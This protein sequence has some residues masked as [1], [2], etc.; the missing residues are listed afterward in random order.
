MIEFFEQLQERHSRLF[1][2][3]RTEE[4]L[5]LLEGE[6]R[7]VKQPD[8][9]AILYWMRLVHHG[10][11]MLADPP[12]PNSNDY[13]QLAEYVSCALKAYDTGSA[14]TQLVLGEIYLKELSLTKLREVSDSLA[15]GREFSSPLEP[16]QQHIRR[17]A[18]LSDEGKFREGIDVM[19]SALPHCRNAFDRMR[20]GTL[21]V[22]TY[23]HKVFHGPPPHG[24]LDY[25]HVR[26]ALRLALDNYDQASPEDRSWFEEGGNDP[27]ALRKILARMDRDEPL[28][29]EDEPATAPASK[30]ERN[31]MADEANLK[32]AASLLDDIEKEA[33][34]IPYVALSFKM[35]MGQEPSVSK[36]E[37]EAI[38]GVVERLLKK[39]ETVESKCGDE[40]GLQ[41]L[42]NYWRG[43][44][45]AVYLPMQFPIPRYKS[46]K[47]QAIACYSRALDLSTAD[48]ER[49]L[50]HYYLGR[51]YH[52]WDQRDASIGNLEKTV[53]LR[54]VDDPMGMD[55]AK[56]LEEIRSE[57]KKACFVVTACAGS[58]ESREVQVLSAFR[59]EVLLRNSCGQWFTSSYER[60]SP[61]LAR[62]IARHA[63]LQK[64]VLHIFVRPVAAIV[65]L[66]HRG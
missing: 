30:G 35:V 19:R 58:S 1:I 38:R 15:K 36:D 54:T 24:T 9:R 20:V 4:A 63:V 17:S 47:D 65:G 21:I 33:K 56:T 64:V 6:L 16:L 29:D 60:V 37:Q 44:L 39:C 59:D 31:S 46:H 22:T 48:D 45:Y 49:G 12:V 25:Q 13:G 50:V 41:W 53:E 5:Q 66:R 57:R 43:R 8:E 42:L 26:E 28:E 11:P 62:V 2:S 7:Q 52:V 14:R 18:N 32:I 51:L 27:E 10:F 61:G 55:A 23:F 40:S 3:G 34:Q